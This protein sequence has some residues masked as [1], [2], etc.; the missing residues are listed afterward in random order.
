M[1]NSSPKRGTAMEIIITSNS[2][3]ATASIAYAPTSGVGNRYSDPGTTDS[4]GN[5]ELTHN[6]TPDDQPA[7]TTYRVA[8]KVSTASCSTTFTTS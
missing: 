3:R 7:G 2:P 6:A 8:V 1:G 5:L 4:N